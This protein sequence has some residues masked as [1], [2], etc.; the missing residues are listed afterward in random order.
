MFLIII[1]RV[2]N[3]RNQKGLSRMDNPDTLTPLGTQDK[4]PNKT[5]NINK[6]Q[7]TKEETPPP[8]THTRKFINMSNTDPSKT[9]DDCKCSRRVSSSRLMIIL[10][11]VYR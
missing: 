11:Y 4:G 8:H 3:K 2:S 9:G 7:Q 6:K 5:K 1:S 10:M